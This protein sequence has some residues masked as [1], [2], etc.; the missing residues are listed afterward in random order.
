M[1]SILNLSVCVRRRVVKGLVGAVICLAVSAAGAQAHDAPVRTFTAGAGM[2]LN[3]IKAEAT[4]DFEEILGKVKEALNKSED[5]KHRELAAGWKTFKAKEP[6]PGG[7]VFYVMVMDPAIPG[8][9]YAVGQ[10]LSGAF[11]TEVQVLYKK[12]SEAYA[13]G[14]NLLN[15]DL[16]N[17][18]GQ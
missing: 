10:I 15:L 16:V 9:E 13:G 3:P 2:I 1:G 4:A 11:P 7:S 17:D 14:Q 6:G 5:P 12:F 8:G 18:F